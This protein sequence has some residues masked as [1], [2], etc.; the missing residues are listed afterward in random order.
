MYLLHWKAVFEQSNAGCLMNINSQAEEN[1]LVLSQ[2]N[3]FICNRPCLQHLSDFCPSL[4]FSPFTLLPFPLFF[5]IR[6]CEL[7]STTKTKSFWDE[8][9]PSVSNRPFLIKVTLKLVS[10][11][12]CSICK[13]TAFLYR[14][15]ISFHQK[16][17]WPSSSYVL[18]DGNH[19]LSGL[20]TTRV[21]QASQGCS[22][23]LP[24]PDLDGQTVITKTSSKIASPCQGTGWL[25]VSAQ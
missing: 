3:N 21:I 7:H 20:L 6:K 11:G 22:T 14:L 24:S 8:I 5:C 17:S 4:P 16:K 19:P 25:C 12:N 9:S 2:H 13:E 1:K 18:E 23:R 10:F 15:P